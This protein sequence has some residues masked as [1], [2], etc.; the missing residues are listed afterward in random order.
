MRIDGVL[1]VWKTHALIALVFPEADE[2]VG[3]S[4]KN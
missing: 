4:S 3:I 2:L 1:M